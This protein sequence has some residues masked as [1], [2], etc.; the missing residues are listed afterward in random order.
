MAL[1]HS[2][3]SFRNSNEAS[4]RTTP[5]QTQLG[6]ESPPQQPKAQASVQG[7]PRRVHPGLPGTAAPGA[8]KRR[9]A[10]RLL[11]R[12]N[13]VTT[14]RHLRRQPHSRHPRRRVIQVITHNRQGKDQT[15]QISLLI[16]RRVSTHQ[17]S[18]SRVRRRTLIL[19]DYEAIVESD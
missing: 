14:G 9:R 12:Y 19:A 6:E 17:L 1:K 4:I 16:Y 18:S 13:R 7:Q 10:T 8:I 5:I 11:P 15:P 3:R 2:G